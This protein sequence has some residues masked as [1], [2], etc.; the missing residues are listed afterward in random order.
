MSQE[1]AVTE[2]GPCSKS[3]SQAVLT[4]HQLPPIGLWEENPGGQGLHFMMIPHAAQPCAEDTGAE[5]MMEAK[6]HRLQTLCLCV[7]RAQ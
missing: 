1:E 2:S 6:V 5:L 4:P 7:F 3:S